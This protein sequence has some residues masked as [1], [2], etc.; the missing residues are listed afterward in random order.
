[1]NQAVRF[2][3]ERNLEKRIQVFDESSATVELAAAAIGCQ[4]EEIAKTISLHTASIEGCM[5]IV[6]AGDGKIDNAKFKARFG[7]KAVMLKREEVELFTGHPVGG[8]C[9]FV[10]KEGVKV[11]LDVSLKRF[12]TVYTACGTPNSVIGLTPDEL[13]KLAESA[14]WVDVCKGWF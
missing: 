10:L 13:W 5:L 14:D 11:Y 12:Q 8:V 3:Q 6:A 1:M 2:F 7:H 9:P 4:P